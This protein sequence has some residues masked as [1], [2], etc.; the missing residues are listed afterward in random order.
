MS[1]ALALALSTLV[2]LLTNC[3]EHLSQLPSGPPTENSDLV[4]VESVRSISNLSEFIEN[5]QSVRKNP[6]ASPETPESCLGVY[7]Q[8]TVFGDNWSTFRSAAYNATLDNPRIPDIA[9]ILQVIAT[10][11]D[12]NSVQSRLDRLRSAITRCAEANIP[13]YSIVPQQEDRSTI[14]LNSD[15]AT[16]IYRADQSRLLYVAANGPFDT[17]RAALEIINQLSS[18]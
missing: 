6:E 4:S 13:F 16:Y 8:P 17:S 3:S 1:R 9:S 14:V 5:P 10:Y 2:L 11:P 7:D 12:N 18:N 15:E